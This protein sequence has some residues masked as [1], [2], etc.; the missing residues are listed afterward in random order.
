MYLIIIEAKVWRVVSAVDVLPYM[1][2]RVDCIRLISLIPDPIDTAE[3]GNVPHSVAHALHL[4]L[5][6]NPIHP[7]RQQTYD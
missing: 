4:M 6:D 5:P 1:I 2:L 3:T 7:R